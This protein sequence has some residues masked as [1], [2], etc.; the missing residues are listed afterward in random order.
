MWLEMVIPNHGTE[1]PRLELRGTDREE[2]MGT[3][4]VQGTRPGSASCWER[5]L[6][7][8]ILEALDVLVEPLSGQAFVESATH[9]GTLY[10]V[11]AHTCTC[12]AGERGLICKHRACYLAQIGELPLPAIVPAAGRP[13]GL[14]AVQPVAAVAA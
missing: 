10:A 11:S 14:P 6:Q 12:P 9:P 13:Y 2:Q 5:A 1:A 7:R 4:M 3:T 8:A